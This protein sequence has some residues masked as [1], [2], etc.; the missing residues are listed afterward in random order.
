MLVGSVDLIFND[1][2]YS[3]YLIIVVDVVERERS[4]DED[5]VTR[6]SLVPEV[7]DRRC[8]DA[9]K[10]GRR[11][12]GDVADVL[13]VEIMCLHYIASLTLPMIP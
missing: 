7:V 11:P 4:M 13:G 3:I 10:L 5:M 1:S 12:K 6:R 9:K 2:L 8:G